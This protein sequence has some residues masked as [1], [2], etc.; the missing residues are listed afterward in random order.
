MRQFPRWKLSN[1]SLCKV[2]AYSKKDSLKSGARNFQGTKAP[3][4]D[5]RPPLPELYSE[6]QREYESV[7][8]WNEVSKYEANRLWLFSS[9]LSG[10]LEIV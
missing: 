9:R 3:F 4:I 2:L 7:R 6:Q 1:T 8:G 10:K 5:A